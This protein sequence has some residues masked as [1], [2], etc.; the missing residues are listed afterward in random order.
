MRSSSGPPDG[1]AEVSGTVV[2][3]T[4]VRSTLPAGPATRPNPARLRPGASGEALAL[5]RRPRLDRGDLGR[6]LVG[7]AGVLTGEDELAVGPEP[8]DGR[9]ADPDDGVDV[10]GEARVHVQQVVGGVEVQRRDGQA[11]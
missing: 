10:D 3:T 1:R 8:E 9:Q 11:H 4:R 2:V 5:V 7:V 6:L